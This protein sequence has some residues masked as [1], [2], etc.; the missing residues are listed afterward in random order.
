MIGP[1]SDKD[2]TDRITDRQNHKRGDFYFPHDQKE[3]S[4]NNYLDDGN[5][6]CI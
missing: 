3:T 4:G 6:W 2:Q 1:G 5:T